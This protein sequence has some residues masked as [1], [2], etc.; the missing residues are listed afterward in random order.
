MGAFMTNDSGRLAEGASTPARVLVTGSQGYIGSVLVRHLRG[1]GYDVIERDLGLY[2]AC[3]YPSGS[4]QPLGW[5]VREARSADFDGVDAVVHLAALSNDPLGDLDPGLTYAINHDGTV[6]VAEAAKD[7]GVRRFVFASSCSLYGASESGRLLDESAPMTPLTPYAETKVTAEAA[8]GKLADDDFSP[9]YMRNAT[10]YGPSSALRL[11]IVVND[12]CAT[13]AATGR[14][15]LKSDGSA[16]RPQVHVEDVAR[17]VRAVLEAPIESVHDQAFNVG[18]TE[19][20]LTINEIAELVSEGV[21]GGAPVDYADDAGTDPRSYRVD[22]TKIAEHVPSFQPRWT[23]AEGIR[24][25]L[26]VF[27]ADGMTVDDFPRY[28]RLHEIKRLLGEGRL[29]E[30]LVWARSSLPGA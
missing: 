1:H 15:L 12:L 21:P 13:A 22:F 17:S 5:D 9:T 11:D 6:R 18:R 10:V 27:L 26:K 19:D 23:L 28:R 7:A 25:L 16:W 30:S 3:R 29:E 20:N 24:Q 14:I 4:V 2:T 8:L